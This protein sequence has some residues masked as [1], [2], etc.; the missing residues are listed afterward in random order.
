VENNMGQARLI[1][2]TRY[3]EA[4]QTKTRLIPA[5]GAQGAADLQKWMTEQVVA[6]IKT[7][8]AGHDLVAGE[9]HYAGGND[10]LIRDW[11]AAD[12]PYIPQGSGSLGERL[13]RAFAAAFASGADRVVVVGSDCPGLNPAIFAGAFAALASHD[14]VLGPATD[15][16]YYLIGLTAPQP[17]L[18]TDISWG[19]SEVFETTRAKAS[20][21]QLTTHI[22]EQL[23]DVDRP[24]DLR[25]FSN[26]PDS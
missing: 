23:A 3:P 1:L 16:G 20:L 25:H 7:F 18:F 2:F 14:L 19:G 9:I 4:G 6:Q 13:E 8:L 22:L 5:L 24:E 11:L 17:S 21:L 26:H 12:L 10:L 15:G